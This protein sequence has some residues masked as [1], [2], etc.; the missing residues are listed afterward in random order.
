[1]NNPEVFIKQFFFDKD[2][3]KHSEN[4]TKKSEII[5]QCRLAY[6]IGLKVLYDNF[7]ICELTNIEWN[8][9]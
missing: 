6:V 9:D 8:A 3:K 5:N 7:V 1:M 2:N 4:Y